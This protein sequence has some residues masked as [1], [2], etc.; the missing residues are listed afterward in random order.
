VGALA[1]TSLPAP[2]FG[3]IVG[4]VAP[5]LMQLAAKLTF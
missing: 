1:L 5:R 4:A 3:Q 2:N